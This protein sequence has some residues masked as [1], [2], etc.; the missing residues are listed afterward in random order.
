M[1]TG[2]NY[3]AY[4]LRLRKIK[5]NDRATWVASVQSVATDEQRS[6]PNVEALATF[7]LATFQCN[8]PI[9][10]PASQAEPGSLPR[11]E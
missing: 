8:L 3:A 9:D 5:D 1:S 6:F 11:G 10:D 2:T 4:L 7:L